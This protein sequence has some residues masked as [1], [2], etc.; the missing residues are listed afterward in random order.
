MKSEYVELAKGKALQSEKS[1][2]QLIRTATAT[3]ERISKTSP[4][5]EFDLEFALFSHAYVGNNPFLWENTFL[6]HPPETRGK[7]RKLKRVNDEISEKFSKFRDE[8]RLIFGTNF[9]NNFT[10]IWANYSI[11]S[12]FTWAWNFQ[13]RKNFSAISAEIVVCMQLSC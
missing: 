2:C 5:V 8:R 1:F 11:I 13:S 7:E 9:E 10:K 6:K 12:N 4:Y 3:N